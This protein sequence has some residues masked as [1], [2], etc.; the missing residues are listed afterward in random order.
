M[1]IF[2]KIEAAINDGAHRGRGLAVS[3]DGARRAASYAADHARHVLLVAEPA[4]KSD[5][6]QR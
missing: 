1:P 5:L 4:L 6:R 2:C 3:A